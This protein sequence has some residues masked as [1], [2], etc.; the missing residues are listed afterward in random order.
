M[1][2][3]GDDGIVSMPESEYEE[4]Q[5]ELESS[6][7]AIEMLKWRISMLLDTYGLLENERELLDTSWDAIQTYRVTIDPSVIPE[8]S[9]WEH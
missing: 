8:K 9:R 7:Y 5:F 1:I 4:L 2:G 6:T 3:T